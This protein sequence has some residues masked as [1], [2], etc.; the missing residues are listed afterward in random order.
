MSQKKQAVIRFYAAECMEFENHGEFRENLTLPEAVEAY[1]R[2]R[3]RNGASGPGIGFVLDDPAIPLYSG[4]SWPLYEWGSVAHDAIALIPAYRDHPLVQQA[5]RDIQTY[6]PRLER[7]V[8]EAKQRIER[9]MSK[10][11]KQRNGMER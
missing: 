5:V 4:G 11:R 6:V 10:V 2:I 8:D 1:I 7:A 9:E 3:R